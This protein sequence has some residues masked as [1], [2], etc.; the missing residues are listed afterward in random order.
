MRDTE[1]QEDRGQGEILQLRLTL[2]MCG[3]S[4]DSRNNAWKRAKRDP[5]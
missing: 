5:S 1:K 4:H 2:G 3:L